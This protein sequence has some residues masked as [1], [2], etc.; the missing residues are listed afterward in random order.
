MLARVAE[1]MK[2][3]ADHLAL[4]DLQAGR[5][6]G[7]EIPF[8]ELDEY[9]SRPMLHLRDDLR[10]PRMPVGD[11]MQHVADEDHVNAIRYLR[12]IDFGE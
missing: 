4:G 7:R 8:L 10:H 9:Q 5:R 3:K 1:Q 11:V 12:I 6:P 2:A